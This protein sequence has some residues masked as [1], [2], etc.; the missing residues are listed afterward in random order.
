MRTKPR[1]WAAI[2]LVASLAFFGVACSSDSDDGGDPESSTSADAGGDGSTTTA[3]GDGS[4]T[5]A[6]EETT[7][8]AAE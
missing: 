4:T 6:G 5:T 1:R 3:G 7:T 2:A 8:S